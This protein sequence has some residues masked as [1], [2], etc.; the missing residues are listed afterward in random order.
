MCSCFCLIAYKF[1]CYL[2][3]DLI[4]G[5]DKH[6]KHIVHIRLQ[7]AMHNSFNNVQEIEPQESLHTNASFGF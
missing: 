7:Q 3:I 6:I 1:K 5:V 4:L 2:I